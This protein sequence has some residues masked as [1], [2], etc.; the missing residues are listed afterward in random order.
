[1]VVARPFKSSTWYSISEESLWGLAKIVVAIGV[2]LAGYQA[3][4]WWDEYTVQQRASDTLEGARAMLDGFDQETAESYGVE[5]AEARANLGEAE[6][7]W[8]RGAF[9][10]ALLNARVSRGI[11][12]DVLDSIRNPGRKGEARFIYVEGEVDY[13]RGETGQFRRARP[14][15][16]LFEGDYV[17]SSTRGSAE[18]LFDS[19]GTLFTVRP[20][21]MLKVQRELSLRGRGEPVRMEYGWVDLETSRRPSGIETEFAA[22]KLDNESEATVMFEPSSATGRFSVGRGDGEVQAPSSGESRRL[23][24]LEQVVQK[25]ED[26]GETTDLLGQPSVVGPPNNFDLNLD[27]DREVVLSWEKVDS[28]AGYILQVSR[29]RL[30]G[31]RVVDRRREKTSATL[32]LKGEGNFF[33]RVAAYGSDREPGPWSQLRK[34]RVLSMGGLSWEDTVAPSLEVLRVNVNGNIVIVTGKTEPGVRLEVDG[35]RTSVSADG[36]FTMSLTPQGEGHVD[37]VVSAVDASGNETAIS[38]GVFIE[39]M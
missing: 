5:L 17:R 23:S 13:R 18:L 39:P 27:R 35:Q 8:E 32:E 1:V 12:V 6:D 25:R 10:A 21:T 15:D 28:A 36:S 20:G 22:L 3:Y 7:A 33:W 30:F 16:V 2:L 11:A 26:L 31:D 4:V 14:R 29:N 34:F 38:R 24:E 9:R 19:D 37:L